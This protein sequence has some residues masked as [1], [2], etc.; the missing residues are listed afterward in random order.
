MNLRQLRAEARLLQRKIPGLL[1][2]FFIPIMIL[3][4]SNFLG[5]S[6]EDLMEYFASIDLKQAFYLEVSR[7]LFSQVINFIISLFIISASYALID[8]LRRQT[9]QLKFSDSLRAFSNQIFTP[10]VLTLFCM[11]LI[12]FCWS[13]LLWV[14]SVISIFT[15]YR[16]LY[17]YNQAPN[18][19]LS[20]QAIQQISNYS[21]SLFLG[22]LLVTLGLIISLPQRYAYSQAE[23]ILYDQLKEGTYQGPLQVLRQSRLMMKGYKDKRFMLDVSFIGWQVL[24]FLTLGLAGIYVIP[25]I[26]TSSVLFYEQ[27]KALK[28]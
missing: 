9:E 21:P 25:Y 24:M 14:G 10:L 22:L 26:H 27:L 7:G 16:I 18:N 13:I 12:L 2:L 4:L 23:F 1:L 3:L 8:L 17:I 11:R 20:D 28:K 5:D 19:Q 15:S 6:Q